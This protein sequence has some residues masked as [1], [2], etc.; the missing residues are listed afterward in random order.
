MILREAIT[1][2]KLEHL[3]QQALR[4]VRDAVW[5]MK[6]REDIRGNPSE[7]RDAILNLALYAVQAMPEG[8]TIEV[9]GAT[10]EGAT[11]TLCLPAWTEAAI[12]EE[13]PT[14]PATAG[15]PGRLLEQFVPGT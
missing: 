15:R 11:F 8:G 3:R 5:Q 14:T 10:G 7:W 13:P 9:D 12:S 1:E 4:R 6:S 2:S